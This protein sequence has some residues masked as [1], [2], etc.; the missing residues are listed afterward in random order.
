MHAY[1]RAH[2]PALG[3]FD[4]AQSSLDFATLHHVMLEEVLSLNGSTW[5][6]LHGAGVLRACMFAQ[7][8]CCFL[9]SSSHL[10][11]TPLV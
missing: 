6:T 5:R 8:L 11:L 7:T 3:R 9:D 4:Q 2:T 10:G 1:G